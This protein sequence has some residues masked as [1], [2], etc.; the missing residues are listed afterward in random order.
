MKTMNQDNKTFR[1]EIGT[2]AYKD[3]RDDYAGHVGYVYF[4]D[5]CCHDWR[6]QFF[7]IANNELLRNFDL[8]RCKVF[9]TAKEVHTQF[10]RK[11]EE[12]P[13]FPTMSVSDCISMVPVLIRKLNE[14]IRFLNNF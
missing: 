12:V 4:C 9:F 6:I 14:I 13:E 3:S 8:S 2:G 11:I 7:S 5:N 1:I 10:S